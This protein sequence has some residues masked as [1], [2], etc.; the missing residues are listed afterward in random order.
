MRPVRT[1]SRK[2]RKRC[3][4]NPQRP[5]ASHLDFGGEDMVRAAW[6]HAGNSS[7]IPCRVRQNLPTWEV[8]PE[9]NPA[10]NGEAVSLR[11]A[12]PR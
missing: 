10:H 12:L 5:Y 1:I 9:Y 2:G 6:R 3:F 7:E 8:I 4:R 11:F